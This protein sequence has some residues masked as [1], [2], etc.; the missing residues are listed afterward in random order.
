MP[1]NPVELILYREAA[2]AWSAVIRPWFE[3]GRGRLERS[4]VVVPTRGQ[5]HALKQRC[6]EESVPLLGVDFL[7][8]GLARRKWLASLGEG[9]PAGVPALGRE[10]LLIGLRSLIEGRL[11][12]LQPEDTMWGLW[13]TLQSD[14][15]R[16]LE[17]FD[18]MLRA[19]FGP[20]DFELEPLRELFGELSR[21]ARSLGYELAPLQN[22]EAALRAP[23]P[24]TLA[25]AD[26]LLVYGLGPEAWA[27]F[28]PVVSLARRCRAI[29][30]VLPEPEFRG[31]KSLDERWIELWTAL[32]GVEPRLPDAESP[33][34][35][36]AVAGLWTGAEGS[37]ERA[38][39]L[40][41]RTRSDEM[42]LVAGEVERLLARGA[43]N[44]GVVFPTADSAHLRLARLLSERGVAFADLVE[45]AAAPP[46]DVQ[47]LRAV[48]AFYQGGCS[49]EGL[50]G[51]WPLAHALNLVT[52]APS[53][54]R[55]ACE[56][57]FDEAQTHGLEAYR[58]RLAS[59]GRADWTEIARVAGILLPPWP[60][61]LALAEAMARFEAV[62]AAFKLSLPEGWPSLGAFAG[63]EARPLPLRVVLSA[64]DSFLPRE[65]PAEG[66]PGRGLFARV[67]LTT[68]RRAAGVAWSHAVF[69]ESNAGVWPRRRESSCWLTDE[70]RK[71]LNEKGR[72]SLGLFT[73]DDRAALEKRLCTSLA[74]DTAE[75]IVFTAA[76]FDE[77]EPE[78]PLAPNAW[79]E[80]VMLSGTRWRP[81]G[82]GFEEAFARLARSAR[83]AAPAH[84]GTREWGAVWS[85]GAIRRF[86]STNF[87]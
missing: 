25:A 32:L 36:G 20:G 73:G 48:L 35:C 50:M 52:E 31:S 46:I 45:V 80:R 64:I 16:A 86:P 18:E 28:F 68:L 76:L 15:E 57:L 67:T 82:A 17:D 65:A 55:S 44:V 38:R 1:T 63:R 74:R 8:P 77:E 19:G 37:A 62:C 24:G 43:A 7:T 51:L 47:L 27:E 39:L 60:D 78:L 71:L 75:E 58:N 59:G 33:A 83:K 3:A 66:A 5:A 49:L 13:K 81:A 29:T 87:S 6:A 30:V 21:W 42:E 22:Q 79:V 84:A 23:C 26:R 2:P 69:V 11:A 14:P 85:R 12:G 10:L 53:A 54:V 4:L 70:H 41:G 56:R 61:E 72:F 34:G 40:V 9:E